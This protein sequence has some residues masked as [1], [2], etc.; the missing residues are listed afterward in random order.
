MY[1]FGQ[2]NVALGVY[3]PHVGNPE[4]EGKDVANPWTP[5]D[6]GLTILLVRCLRRGDSFKGC[7][8][9]QFEFDKYHVSLKYVGKRVIAYCLSKNW[10]A[11]Q[12]FKNFSY[13]HTLVFF[14]FF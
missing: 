13:H 4:I 1:A 11:T 9:K 14:A 6:Y 3:A 8:D 10:S 2:V 5:V 7:V 12:S